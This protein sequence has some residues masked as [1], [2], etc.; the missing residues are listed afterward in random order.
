MPRLMECFS[1][2]HKFTI[3]QSFGGRI[4]QRADAAF[5]ARRNHVGFP[6]F[7]WALVVNLFYRR[8]PRCEI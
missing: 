3:H 4:A 8:V 7:K 5:P 1:A 2:L 6:Y